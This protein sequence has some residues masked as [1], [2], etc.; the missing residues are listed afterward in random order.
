MNILYI[1]SAGVLSIQPFNALLESGI[2]VS[3]VGVFKP[4]HFNNKIIALEN[5]SLALAANSSDVP[6]IDLSLPVAEIVSQCERLSISLILMSCYSRRLPNALM[7]LAKAGCYNMHPSLLPKFRGPEPIF[8]QMK[9]ASETG[10]SWHL[11]EKEF[12]TGKVVSQKKILLDDGASYLEICAQIANTGT[13][14]MMQLLSDLTENSLTSTEQ[15]FKLASYQHYPEAQDFVIDLNGS[16]RQAYNFMCAAQI[17]STSF[18]CRIANQ[19]FYLRQALGYD[20]NSSLECVEIQ[21]DRLYIPC[22]EG[23]LIATYTDKMPV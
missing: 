16:A 17:F 13:K 11:V 5:A 21:A 4:V 19:Q 2:V 15:N 14:L 1:G 12:D 22:H 6:V 10:V 18:I 9:N 7:N 3:A 8:W 20:N 23:V